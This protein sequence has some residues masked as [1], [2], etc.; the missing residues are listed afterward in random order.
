MNYLLMSLI[1]FLAVGCANF[2]TRDQIEREKQGQAQEDVKK[3]GPEDSA[4]EGETPG[5]SQQLP[6]I[7]DQ[8][9]AP[10]LKIGLVFGPSGLRAPAQI[11]V[12][13]ELTKTKLP[14]H[15][16]AGMEMGALVAAFYS[17][18]GQSNDAEWKYFK[19]KEEDFLERSFLG[20]E[21]KARSIS[22][23]EPYLKENFGKSKMEK[24]PV[25]FSCP[26]LEI[27]RARSKWL[28]RGEFAEILPFCLAYP[29]LWSPFNGHVA[30]TFSY[31]TVAENLRAGG[32][33]YIV[34]VDVVGQESGPSVSKI[35]TLSS[36][37]W[38]M[39]EAEA[40]EKKA[41]YDYVIQVDTRKYDI[42][43]FQARR[44]LLR[45]GKTQGRKEADK[46]VEQHGL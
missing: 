2:K 42:I 18:A 22:E 8:M 31:G 17:Q 11:G 6:E 12:L 7:P 29:P 20:G 14:I 32:A 34:L 23:L 9:Q 33:N 40:Q 15:S 13:Q 25:P 41:G 30:D 35:G 3:P 16:V 1:L 19:L 5:I 46:L 38:A 39:T 21:I 4:E 28:S 36:I 27:G 44:D 24:A 26:S 43:D 10:D 45:L 37:L